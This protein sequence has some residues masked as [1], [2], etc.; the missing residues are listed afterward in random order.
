[1]IRVDTSGAPEHLMDRDPEVGDV[2]RV[3]GGAGGPRFALIVAIS[4][5]TAYELKFRSDGVPCGVGQ[6]GLHYLRRR[7]R[8]GRVAEIPLIAVEWY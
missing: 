3:T 4:G 2:Y 7:E 5:E 1:M 8:V 6:S